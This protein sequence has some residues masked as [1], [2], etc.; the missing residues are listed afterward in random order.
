MNKSEYA[1][2]F[3]SYYWKRFR[4]AV[5]AFWGD[6][7]NACGGH[8]GI[9]IHHLTYKTLGRESVLDVSPF[10]DSC[11]KNMHEAEGGMDA[12]DWPTSTKEFFQ[13]DKLKPDSKSL[14]TIRP[15]VEDSLIAYAP[16]SSKTVNLKGVFQPIEPKPR[17]GSVR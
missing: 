16:R 7:C 14:G 9:Q 10:C 15:S 17:S 5:L 13:W 3:K 2:Y 12:Y 11:H 8:N 4:L 1:E 6:D